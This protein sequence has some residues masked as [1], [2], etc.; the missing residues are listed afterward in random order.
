MQ[1]SFQDSHYNTDILEVECTYFN[2]C[3]VCKYSGSVSVMHS[4]YLKQSR[5]AL[6]L[7][8]RVFCTRWGT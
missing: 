2:T 5:E 7:S 8:V 3:A 1:L 4:P 6:Q